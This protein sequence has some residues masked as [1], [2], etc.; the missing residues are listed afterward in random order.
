MTIVSPA[1]TRQELWISTLEP[2]CD[3]SFSVCVS[4]SNLQNGLIRQATA[5]SCKTCMLACVFWKSSHGR[6]R[7]MQ[8]L[9]LQSQDMPSHQQEA[10]PQREFT[11]EISLLLQETKGLVK[12]IRRLSCWSAAVSTC[13]SSATVTSF[14]CKSLSE[15][16]FCPI[17]PAIASACKV[18]E[19]HHKLNCECVQK[20]LI[21]SKRHGR[22]GLPG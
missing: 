3:A 11:F 17:V 8:F 6:L 16:S 21:A 22:T 9:S 15:R 1:Q 12:T 5:F 18:A 2:R 14:L 4:S 20:S 13:L 7:Q 10:L 19:S